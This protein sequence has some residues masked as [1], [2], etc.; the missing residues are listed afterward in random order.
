MVSYHFIYGG[1]MATIHSLELFVSVYTT[2]NITDTAKKYYCS[3]PS[4]SRCM[5][6]LEEEYHTV[7]FERYHHKLLPTPSADILYSHALR[8][9][10]SYTNLQQAMLTHNEKIRIGS[11]VTMSNTLLPK[12]I[13]Q[14]TQ[15]YP[16]VRIEVSVSNG[17]SIYHDLLHNSIDIAFIEN[18]IS[19]PDVIAIPFYKDEL[20]LLVPNDHPFASQKSIPLSSLNTQPFLHREQGSAVRQYLDTFLEQN[21]I[22][23]DTLW[24]SRSTHAILHAVESGLGIT[25]LPKNMC[26]KEIQAHTVTQV[27]ITS[28][29]L[30]RPYYLAYAKG[31]KLT[32]NLI[33]FIHLFQ[34]SV[35]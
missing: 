23:V 11:T 33:S 19:S 3:Q 28:H 16:D 10:D 30:I 26:I 29:H 17:E 34:T 31:K 27:D 13:K 15:Q 4:V 21:H 12:Y 1:L 35:Q 9:L 14:Y 8:V 25:I 18:T 32:D 22:H 24:Q 2:K 20:V 5:K 6:D 7:L